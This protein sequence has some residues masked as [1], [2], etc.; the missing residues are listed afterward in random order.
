MGAADGS[1]S[2]TVVGAALAYAERGWPVVPV[3]VARN[4]ACGCGRADCSKPGKHPRAE[5]GFRSATAVPEEIRRTFR[6]ESNVG[7]ATGET[8]GVW[9]LDVDGERGAASLADLVARHGELPVTVESRT[10][11]GGRHLFFRYPVGHAVRNSVRRLGPGLDT[12]ADGG[13]VVAPP[14]RHASGRAY[15][16]AQGRA[17]G[18]VEVAHA[19]AWL[20]E[21]LDGGDRH[22]AGTPARAPRDPGGATAANAYA[23]AALDGETMAVLGAGEGTRNDTLH[24]AAVKL[25]SLVGAGLLDRR[26]VEHE[27]TKAALGCGLLLHEIE[28]TLRSGLNF[29]VAN[30]RSLEGV[31]SAQE[32][33]RRAANHEAQAARRK[34]LRDNPAAMA[35]LT[36]EMRLEQGTLDHFAFGLDKPYES[37]KTGKVFA[38]ALTFPLRSADGTAL[39]VICKANVPGVTRHPKAAWWSAA[40]EA[41]TFYAEPGEFAAVLVCDMP[42]LWRLWQD[43]RRGGERP[44]I[45][46]VASSEVEATPA[47]WF[48]AEFWDRWSEIHVATAADARGDRVAQEVF[49]A[50][51][52]AVRRL[53]P[54]AATWREV[55]ATGTGVGDFLEAMVDAQPMEESLRSEDDAGLGRKAY[56]PLDIGRAFHNGHLYYPVDTLLTEIEVDK[57]GVVR[58]VERVETVVVRSDGR[59]L[60]A[61]EVPAPKGTPLDKRIMRLSD[62]TLIDGMPKAPA[63]PSWSWPSISTWLKAKD[64]KQ[65]IRHR[66][67]REILE[68]VVSAF[69]DTVWLPYEEDYIVLA[70]TS[71]ASYCQA[72]FQA[73]PLLLL[74]GEPGSGKSTAGIAMSMLSANGTIVGQVN[75]AAAAR[76]IHETKGLIVLD[77]LEAIGAR[78]GKDGASFGDL[79]Q[80]LKVSYNRDTATKVWVDAS[81]NFKVERLNGF[82]IKVVNNT[83]GVDSILGSRMIRIQTRKMPQAQAD[84]RRDLVPPSAERLQALRDELHTWTF[85]HVADIA[86]AY[87]E[88]C[89]SATE[90]SEEIAAPLRVLARL[91]G[92]EGHLALLDAALARTSKANLNADDP[93]EVLREA[94]T[95]LARQGFREI[96]PTHIILE[97]KRL[98]DAFFGQVSTTE[99]PEYQQPEWVGRMLRSRD[100]LAPGQPGHRKR[101]FGKNLRVYPFSQNFLHEVLENQDSVPRKEAT[102]FC[103][104]CAACPY[105][106]HGCPFMEERM[107]AEGTRGG[108]Y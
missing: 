19:P 23:G 93:V 10:G 103:V 108:R 43:L 32:A 7:I 38:D 83:T 49:R 3:H 4:G 78:P 69:R 17:P 21:A 86:R 50:A 98:V 46:L 25:G 62:G 5:H 8:A 97:M 42:D 101:F 100:I 79:V 72:V 2:A 34:R 33:R 61:V 55:L 16:W 13:G 52:K 82:G 88:V 77:D 18:E 40:R 68:D 104:G 58:R 95:V 22:R 41:A 15:E 107:A 14:S 91:S 39:S 87:A 29:G 11:G 53:R 47:E 81:R 85:D 48:R 28:A 90:R 30:P 54:S 65:P 60:H 70:L 45:Q 84:A 44:D 31:G 75:A 63:H 89:P 59:Q 27:L 94:A 76:L 80:W 12:R 57:D 106:S 99:I 66:P 92:D 71:A 56:R 20:Y 102:D 96:S 67:F 105:R 51:G 37:A 1:R 9:V 24:A 6:W 35:W 36:G 64:A 74:C 26:Q 73:V